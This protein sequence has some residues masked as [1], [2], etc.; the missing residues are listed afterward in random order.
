MSYDRSSAGFSLLETL[1][2]LAIVG[3]MLAI[4]P[5]AISRSLPN[6]KFATLVDEV[7]AQV[8][9]T[10]AAALY[11]GRETALTIDLRSRQISGLGL[12]NNTQ[13]VKIPEDVEITVRVGET[14]IQ[15]V[16]NYRIRFFPDGT[17][18]GLRL[19]LRRGDSEKRISVEWL[20][21]IIHV[22][23]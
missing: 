16:D 12:H 11:R 6:V 15:S 18:S 14:D 21:G 9:M 4:L 3:L 13:I 20:T 23:R 2:A 19:T 5:A 22:D 1:I 10:K 17:N 8:R 7:A